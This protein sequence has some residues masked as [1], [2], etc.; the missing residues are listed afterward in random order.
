MWHLTSQS[1]NLSNCKA[2]QKDSNFST[3]HYCELVT[4]SASTRMCQ[5]QCQT[6]NK[7]CNKQATKCSVI[8]HMDKI[9]FSFIKLFISGCHVYSSCTILVT[10]MWFFLL[11]VCSES[12]EL[13][14]GYPLLWK[15]AEVVWLL[16]RKPHIIFVYITQMHCFLSSY[17]LKFLF[18][19][20]LLLF[21][22]SFT[23]PISALFSHHKQLYPAQ[24]LR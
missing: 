12:T 14:H 19:K 5:T 21:L 18:S 24:K 6:A 1:L 17:I 15:C 13:L 16:S 4:L 2:G 23:L 11:Y 3:W 8:F 7:H 9:H 10:P 22:F 20:Y